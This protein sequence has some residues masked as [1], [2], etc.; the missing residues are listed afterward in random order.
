MGDLQ[1]IKLN[2]AMFS[3][4]KIRYIRHLPE[5][6]NIVLIWIMLLV[7][8]GKCNSGGMIFLTENV[9]YTTETLSDELGFETATVTL[10]LRVLE[11][12]GMIQGG[13]ALCIT[14][15]E[16]YQSVEKMV[17]IREQTR[18]R[19]AE[20]RAK[21]KALEAGNGAR[22]APMQEACNADV[23][24]Y[25]NVT[26]NAGVTRSNATEE[27]KE[28]EVRPKN[29]DTEERLKNVGGKKEVVSLKG[30]TGEKHEAKTADSRRQTIRAVTDLFNQICG[31]A[32]RVRMLSA[33]M[34]ENVVSLTERYGIENIELAFRKAA[35]SSVLNGNN[36][37][38]FK[39][40]F[41]WLMDD[42]HLAKTLNGDYDETYSTAEDRKPDD[43]TKFCRG[44][45]EWAE[46][47]GDG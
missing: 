1:W 47:G 42:S 2:L 15:W 13:G 35:S 14:N 33:P 37:L 29:T 41:G 22:F 7:L 10:A 26:C 34:E 28:K 23:T 6:N 25:S 3:N 38:Q 9:P 36:K 12:L 39:A 16:E 17:R 27:E 5:G 24:R 11:E 44:M 8:A 46:G 21:Q 43:L 31:Y 4:R 18:K 40:T 32:S 30:G 19:V 20:H 45:A